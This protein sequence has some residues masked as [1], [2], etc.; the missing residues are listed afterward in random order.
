MEIPDLLSSCISNLITVSV[1]LT[2]FTF[3]GTN[4]STSIVVLPTHHASITLVLT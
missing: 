3:T 4:I 1:I 2:G